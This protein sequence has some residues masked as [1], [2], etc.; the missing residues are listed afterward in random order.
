MQ[1]ETIVFIAC[2]VIFTIVAAVWDLRTNRLPN[3][4]NVTAFALGVAFHL[5][6]GFLS[7]GWAG[8]GRH[9]LISLGG[10]AVG[11]GIL[12]VLW[13]AGG[14]GG[15]DV[16]FM[17]A[18]G[19]WLGVKLTL[20]VFVASAVLIALYTA[21]VLLVSILRRGWKKT[22]RDYIAGRKTQK[23]AARTPLKQLVP[24]AVPAAVA[25]WAVLAFAVVNGAPELPLS[26]APQQVTD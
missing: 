13:I 21:G 2:V 12:F 25:T 7:D 17:G 20:Y 22:K 16:K 19:A 1:P 3:A 26:Q 9:L 15:G 4:M 18:L 23:G 14:G 8:A 6:I 5:V 10:F 24:Y 11:F